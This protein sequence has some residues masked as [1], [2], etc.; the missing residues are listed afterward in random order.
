MQIA[1][2]NSQNAAPTLAPNIEAVLVGGDLAKLTSAERV[3][4]YAHVCD[5]LGL[6]KLTRPFDF[7][8]LNGKLTMYARR[9]CAEQLRRI[10]GVSLRIVSQT[11]ANDMITVIV[12]A[13]NAAGRTDSDMGVLTCKGLGGENLAN[14][15]MKC[16]TKAKRRVTLSLCGLGILDETEVETIPSAQ[17]F[18]EAPASSVTSLNERLRSKIPAK[19]LPIPI[20][21]RNPDPEPESEYEPTPEPEPVPVRL[22][23]QGS[24]IIEVR[25]ITEHKN[26]NGKP[27]WKITDSDGEVWACANDLM[28]ADLSDARSADVPVRVEWA[29]VGQRCVIGKVEG[30]L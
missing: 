17:R 18:V 25:G 2:S 14:A 9:D 16:V 11:V 28:V 4:Y 10:H 26:S 27:I 7:I 5:S 23:M 8:V 3:V 24:T 29:R 21:V 13:T 19:S 1:N 20:P 30:S 15:L 12:E 6:N 22:A